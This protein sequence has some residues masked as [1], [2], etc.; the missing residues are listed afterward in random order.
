MAIVTRTVT[1]EERNLLH[2]MAEDPGINE[3]TRKRARAVLSLLD[4]DDLK[5]AATESGL[6]I[7]TVRKIASLF[8]ERGWQNLLSIPSPRGGDFLS[9]YD[10]G[11]WAERLTRA[12]LDRS[13]HFRAIPYGTSRSEPFTDLQTF[14]Q[15]LIDEFLLQAWSSEGRWKRPDLLCISREYLRQEGGTDAWTPDLQHWDNERC[16]P[17]LEHASAAIEVE[18][19]LWQ[20]SRAKVRL[21]FTIKEEDLDALRNWV[22]GTAIPLYI[23]QVFYDQ[24]YALPF[25]KV[26]YLISDAAPH[27]QRVFAQVDR[28]TRN[29]KL[30][31]ESTKH[32]MA[33]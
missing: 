24:A 20:V 26:E 8:N 9:R 11:F 7:A 5:V 15:H 28:I 6:S 23:V 22:H 31:V 3:R 25:T 17:Y 10:H 4:Q 19:S 16:A 13:Q 12:Y 33:G 32:P 27:E 1:A 21:S 30:R 18:T 29:L 2:T 14:R